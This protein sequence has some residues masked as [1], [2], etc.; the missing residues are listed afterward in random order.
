[1]KISL[2]ISVL[3]F[4]GLLSM[5]LD[6]GKEE[7]ALNHAEVVDLSLS[8]TEMENEETVP[9]VVSISGKA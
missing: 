7:E 5:R 9:K 6:N 1:M 8:G 3:I 4:N 2:S